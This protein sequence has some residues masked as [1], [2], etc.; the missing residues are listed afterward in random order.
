MPTYEYECKSCGRVMDVFQSITAAPLKRHEC[1]AC[2]RVRPVR[3]LLGTGGALIFKGSGFYLTDYRSESYKK[4]AEAESK[5]S[6][7]SPADAPKPPGEAAA[8]K[9]TAA[10]SAAASPPAAA[11]SDSKAGRPAGKRRRR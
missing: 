2:G 4:A 1:A 6:A 7:A 10:K 9:P 3:R 11:S 8:P 5:A